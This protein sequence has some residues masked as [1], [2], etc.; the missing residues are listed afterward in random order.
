MRTRPAAA[1]QDRFQIVQHQFD[2]HLSEGKWS[3]HIASVTGR[4]RFFGPLRSEGVIELAGK[5]V[6]RASCHLPRQVTA[7]LNGAGFDCTGVLIA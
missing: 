2:V 1:T 3:V 7:A 4:G 6:L 5:V